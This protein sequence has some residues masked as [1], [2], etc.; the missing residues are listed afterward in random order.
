MRSSSQGLVCSMSMCRWAFFVWWPPFLQ[1][2]KMHQVTHWTFDQ[3]M[4]S[5]LR[6][7]WPEP[8]HRYL[9]SAD[10]PSTCL[11]DDKEKLEPN[12]FLLWFIQCL[13]N[14]AYRSWCLSVHVTCKICYFKDSFVI[15]LH[16][17][18]FWHWYIMIFN[19]LHKKIF[20]TSLH[21]TA[22][23][24]TYFMAFKMYEE[25]TNQINLELNNV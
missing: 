23:F 9:K 20:F 24:T 16:F 10:L 3:N 1:G 19:T 8:I 11:A 21:L 2:H 7:S 6:R 22:T 13:V 12:K 25:Q 17:W 15:R 18:K 5:N 14:I 4:A